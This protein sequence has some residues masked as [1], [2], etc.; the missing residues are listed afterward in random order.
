MYSLARHKGLPGF[1]VEARELG[2]RP[3]FVGRDAKE[4]TPKKCCGQHR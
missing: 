1:D 3:V 4:L 2:V